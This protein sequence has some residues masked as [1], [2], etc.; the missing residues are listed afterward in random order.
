MYIYVTDS[1]VAPN[2]RLFGCG[3]SI[4]PYISWRFLFGVSIKFCCYEFAFIF[5]FERSEF[6]CFIFLWRYFSHFSLKSD[7][8]LKFLNEISGKLFKHWRN[9]RFS[10]ELRKIRKLNNECII[11]MYRIRFG[12]ITCLI[13]N[14]LVGLLDPSFI[15]LGLFD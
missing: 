12:F 7:I 10:C 15:R 9:A 2:H 11:V 5:A 6:I 1:H 13:R 4:S 3:G 8:F 14:M